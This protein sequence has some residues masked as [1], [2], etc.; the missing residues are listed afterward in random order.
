MVKEVTEERVAG[1]EGPE[2]LAVVLTVRVAV[3]DGVKEV[4]AVAET[5]GERV[6]VI[7]EQVVDVTL[8]ETVPEG[9]NVTV[10]VRVA[11]SWDDCVTL[12]EEEGDDVSQIVI[13][14]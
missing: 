11:L 3:T 14:G 13:V 12:A 1:K 8:L 9:L 2:G 7:E 6:V 5:E 4:Q 10:K